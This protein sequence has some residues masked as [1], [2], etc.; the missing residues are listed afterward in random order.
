VALAQAFGV[1]ARETR[2]ES[3]ESDLSSALADDGPHVIVLP[4][5]LRMFAPTHL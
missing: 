2:P 3:L 4:A 1:P 5:R